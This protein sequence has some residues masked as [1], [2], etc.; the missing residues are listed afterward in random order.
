MKISTNE[1]CE[2]GNIQDGDG[3]D[4]ECKF[5]VGWNHTQTSISDG[6]LSSHVSSP[7]TSPSPHIAVDI[8]RLIYCQS[9]CASSEPG[10]TCELDDSIPPLTICHPTCGDN[11]MIGE[12]QCE[13]GDTDPGDGCDE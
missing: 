8:V 3:C 4:S 7:T 5:E 2:D 11:I 9:G 10:W 13:D 12:E 1:D 6:N